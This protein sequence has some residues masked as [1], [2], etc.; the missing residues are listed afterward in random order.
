MNVMDDT[1][2]RYSTLPENV[3]VYDVPLEDITRCGNPIIID[4]VRYS[5]FEQPPAF[6][7]LRG[8]NPLA[9]PSNM[10]IYQQNITPQV[11][12]P[13]AHPPEV[14]PPRVDSNAHEPPA[15]TKY[16]VLLHDKGKL[17]NPP[18]VPA[19]RAHPPEVPL[20]RVDN[21]THEPPAD[22]M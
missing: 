18:E 7:S 19:P 1:P 9:P 17:D 16:H 14:P 21:T 13:C 6:D 4:D 5:S 11:T 12:S 3:S 8:D 10:N 20:P 15:D 2:Q 22:T